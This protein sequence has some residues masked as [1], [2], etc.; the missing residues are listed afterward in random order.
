MV[1]MKAGTRI[2]TSKT[3]FGTT[4]TLSSAVIFAVEKADGSLVIIATRT[5]SM[6][7]NYAS[8]IEGKP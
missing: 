7:T 4:K 5:C 2:Y 6:I 8:K 1:A 3:R